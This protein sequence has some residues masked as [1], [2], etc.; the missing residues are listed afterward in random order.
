[1]QPLILGIETSSGLCSV[2]FWQG[3]SCLAYAEEDIGF[4][5]ASTFFALLE[6]VQ[7]TSGLILKDT[8]HIAVTRGPGS[9][10]GIRV[11]LSIA[12]G[13]ELGGNLPLLGLTCFEVGLRTVS[14]TPHTLF[15]LDTKRNDFYGAFYE[16][17]HCVETGIWTKEDVLERLKKQPATLI[18]DKVDVFPDPILPHLLHLTAQDVACTAEHHLLKG[19][20]DIFSKD[21]FYL[22]PPKVYE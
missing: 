13:F 15:A 22:R 5:H 3:G 12:K 4:G 20:S 19:S 8:T 21:P 18:A 7:K 6:Q 9:F 11:G 14:H 1:M 10:T 2:C 16:N 17:D